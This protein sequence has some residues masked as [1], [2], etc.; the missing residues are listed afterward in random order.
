MDN[1]VVPKYG[2]SF[3]PPDGEDISCMTITCVDKYGVARTRSV[4]GREA[5]RTYIR[6]LL[7]NFDEVC[8]RLAQAATPKSGPEWSAFE[9]ELERRVE[10][11]REEIE[12]GWADDVIKAREVRDA[13]DLKVEKLQKIVDD[14]IDVLGSHAMGMGRCGEKT[15][16]EIAR[17]IAQAEQDKGAPN[18]QT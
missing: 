5:I 2:I 18:G 13:A 9:H 11:A 4:S 16:V 6:E 10:A 17:Q 8:A 15:V 3:S 7:D 14:V 1:A 12:Q